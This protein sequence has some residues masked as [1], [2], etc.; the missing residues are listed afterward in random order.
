MKHLSA[1][2]ICLFSLVAK[3]QY[4]GAMLEAGGPAGYGSLNYLRIADYGAG[5][6]EARVGYGTYRFTGVTGKFH[7]DVIVPLGLGFTTPLSQRLW[8]GGGITISGIQAYKGNDLVTNWH[9]LGF[10]RVSFAF[11]KKENFLAT[12]TVYVLNEH[13]KHFRPWGG[14]SFSYLW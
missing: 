7:P 14:L 11:L 1:L 6:I 8:F 9:T 3:A 2:F 10:E 12:A 13:E 5:K 4:R